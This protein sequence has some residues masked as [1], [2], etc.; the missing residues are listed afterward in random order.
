MS[1]QMDW[2]R[3]TIKRDIAEIPN[4]LLDGAEEAILQIA[5]LVLGLAQV[6]VRVDT[7]SLRD[8]GRKE[9]GGRGKMW[10]EVKVRFGGYV[11]NP[12][13]GRL[14][15]YAAIIE[16]RYPYLKPAVQEVRPQMDEIIRRLCLAQV[17]SLPSVQT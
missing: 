5:D 17:A 16:S 7:G 6:H 8:S 9:R 10:R 3:G 1:I 15:D 14:V 11:V 13:T 4:K 12:R 2:G